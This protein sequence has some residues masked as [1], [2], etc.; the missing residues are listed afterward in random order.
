MGA[1]TTAPVHPE[2]QWSRIAAANAT[3]YART[4]R[5]S[6]RMS[7]DT[8]TPTFGADSSISAPL[9]WRTSRSGSR[10]PRRGPRRSSGET[11]AATASNVSQEARG[12]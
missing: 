1:S 11:R 5:G 12:G 4:A 9:T 6:P 7:S 2:V 10:P 3:R 8:F